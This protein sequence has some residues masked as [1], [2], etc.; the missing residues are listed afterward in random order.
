MFSFPTLVNVLLFLWSILWASW[1][2]CI[3]LKQISFIVFMGMKLS[4]PTFCFSFSAL[5]SSL[6]FPSQPMFSLQVSATSFFVKYP[7]FFSVTPGQ[8]PCPDWTVHALVLFL[9]QIVHTVCIWSCMHMLVKW[10]SETP[11]PHSKSSSQVMKKERKKKQNFTWCIHA[12][13]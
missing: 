11:R 8:T 1:H 7:L 9:G 3:R 5:C 10:K 12:L 4:S 6:T 2:Y 13:L